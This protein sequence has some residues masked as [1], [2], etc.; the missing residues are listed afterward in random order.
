MI[1]I[2]QQEIGVKDA[3]SKSTAS[4]KKGTRFAM[5]HAANKTSKTTAFQAASVLFR[6]SCGCA[7]CGFAFFKMDMQN[8]TPLIKYE[9]SIW[10]TRHVDATWKAALNGKFSFIMPALLSPIQ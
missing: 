8:T 2:I 6:L 9:M 10:I 1:G 4:P 5:S 3:P 7:Y